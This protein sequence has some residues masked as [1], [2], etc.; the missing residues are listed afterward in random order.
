MVKTRRNSTK[1]KKI[2]EKRGYEKGNP[3]KGKVV[4]HIKPV[5]EGGKDT[6]KNIRVTSE[7]KHKKIHKNRRKRGKI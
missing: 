6:P 7:S 5:A 3:P 2:L 1:I 4:H